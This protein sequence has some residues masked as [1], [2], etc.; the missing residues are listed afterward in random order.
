MLSKFN[1]REEMKIKIVI[2]PKCTTKICN[3]VSGPARLFNSS[4]HLE[5]WE[6]LILWK[7][8]Q[9]ALKEFG[10]QNQ[11]QEPAS[12]QR[13]WRARSPASCLLS[14]LIEHSP[15]ARQPLASHSL[16]ARWPL[17]SYSSA[18]HWLLADHWFA[19]QWLAGSS[20]LADSLASDGL[21]NKYIYSILNLL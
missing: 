7:N 19:R 11:L 8:T 9:R 6:T 18:T 5:K 2:Y 14:A 16:P 13:T 10:E 4:E 20:P 15:T 3:V 12:R 1:H 21:H 17:A